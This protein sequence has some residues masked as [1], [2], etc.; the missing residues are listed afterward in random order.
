MRCTFRN[1]ALINPLSLFVV[2]LQIARKRILQHRDGVI[3]LAW[4]EAKDG[5]VPILLTVSD[6]RSAPAADIVWSFSSHDGN[7]GVV[8][9]NISDVMLL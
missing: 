2:P 6:I 4:A 7:T 8:C 5:T 3:A 9:N 1:K